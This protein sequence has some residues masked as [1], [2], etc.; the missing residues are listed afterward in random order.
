[1]VN[2]LGLSP[3]L[4]A[5]TGHI[6]DGVQRNESLH[7]LNMASVDVPQSA[8]DPFTTVKTY[9]RGS[10]GATLFI[11]LKNQPQS[12]TI[13]KALSILNSNS[14]ITKAFIDKLMPWIRG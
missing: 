9:H 6:Y 13:R 3:C 11:I 12:A 10:H 8:K 4:F 14:R 7:Q 5:K 2:A 1:M